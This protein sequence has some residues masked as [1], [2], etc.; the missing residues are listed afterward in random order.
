MA[1]IYN[2]PSESLTEYGE[3]RAQAMELQDVAEKEDKEADWD[4]AESL[5]VISYTSLRKVINN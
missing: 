1:V 2:V 4:K 3:F 5:L